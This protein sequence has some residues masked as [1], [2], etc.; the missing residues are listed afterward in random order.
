M[1]TKCVNVPAFGAVFDDWTCAHNLVKLK[2]RMFSGFSV[3]VPELV[4]TAVGRH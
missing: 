3:Y 2:S 1:P 4:K